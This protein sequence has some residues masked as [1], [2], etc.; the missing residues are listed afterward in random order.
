MK[1]RI[2]ERNEIKN[3]IDYKKKRISHSQ[4]AL[5]QLENNKKIKTLEKINYQVSLNHINFLE[6][7]L[8]LNYGYQGK[9]EYEERKEINKKFNND[10]FVYVNI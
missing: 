10:S 9:F 4:S 2:K 1:R 7:M 8:H 5:I 3:L 6:S